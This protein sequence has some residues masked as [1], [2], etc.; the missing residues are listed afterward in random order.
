MDMSTTTF[1]ENVSKALS[2]HLGKV[3]PVAPEFLGAYRYPLAN[4][5]AQGA[6]ALLQEHIRLASGPEGQDYLAKVALPVESGDEVTAA[7]ARLATLDAVDRHAQD[8][9]AQLDAVTAAVGHEDRGMES[10]CAGFT[11]QCFS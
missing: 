1:P 11:R 3:L 4:A 2:A 6:D 7:G 5:A 10:I 9:E 8:T